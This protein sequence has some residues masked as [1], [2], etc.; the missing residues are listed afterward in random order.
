MDFNFKMFKLNVKYEVER[1]NTKCDY[2]SFSSAETATINTP[3]SQIYINIPTEVS[4]NS[5]LNSYLDLHFE[6]VKE[7]D[8]SRYANGYDI[9]FVFLGPIVLFNNFKLT[10]SSGK[11]LKEYNHAQIVFLMY[12]L[13]PSAKHSDDLAIGFDR[14]RVRRQRETTNKKNIKGKFHVRI[15]VKHVFG[16]TEHQ[17]KATYG[18]C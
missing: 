11:H 1:K 6:D 17:E 5:L 7:I 3:K 12:K 8:N 18:L 16:V 15:M 4:V 14:D 10:T 9:R 2:K 13:I